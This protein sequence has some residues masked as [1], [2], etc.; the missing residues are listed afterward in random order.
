MRV[1]VHFG[2]FLIYI[3]VYVG[4]SLPSSASIK[5]TRE[6]SEEPT[7]SV[8]DVCVVVVLERSVSKGT[9]VSAEIIEKSIE[10]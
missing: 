10:V 2:F 3:S 4:A 6:T 8:T 5:Y 7:V 9:P 1:E